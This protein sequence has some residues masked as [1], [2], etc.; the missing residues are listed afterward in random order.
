MSTVPR[1][2]RTTSSRR[3]YRLDVTQ[4][5]IAAG[6]PR[7]CCLCPIA[8]AVARKFGAPSAHV[9]VACGIIFRIE[10]RL[11]WRRFRF[12][13]QNAAEEFMADFDIG[14]DVAP[15]RLFIEEID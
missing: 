5:D 13:D 3:L 2:R 4:D 8:L 10:T 12:R 14:R 7:D 15:I 9:I 11:S 6:R 1:S